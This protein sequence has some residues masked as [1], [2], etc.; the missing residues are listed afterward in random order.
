MSEQ[1]PEYE[2]YL[3]EHSLNVRKAFY[4]I[5]RSCPEILKDPDK[6]DYEWSILLHDDTKTVDDEYT[7]YVDY[8]YNRDK[9]GKPK[10][11]FAEKNFRIAKLA[12]FHRNPDHWQHW[13]LVDS[14]GLSIPL[15]MPY[16]FVVEMICNWWSYSWAEG[17]LWSIFDWYEENKKKI[18]V[19]RNTR[20]DI[21]DILDKLK[22]AVERVRGPRKK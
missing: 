18:K 11:K 22:K 19:S 1:H 20:K 10:N 5:R 4:W 8:F 17:D 14:S 12:H 2:K 21:E 6:I 9:N 15:D 7:A 3:K 16:I 13:I